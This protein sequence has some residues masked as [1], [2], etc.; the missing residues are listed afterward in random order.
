MLLIPT[1]YVN[2]LCILTGE[3]DCAL[4]GGA[5]AR[6]K[7]EDSRKSMVESQWWWKVNDVV[8]GRRFSIIASYPAS[9]SLSRFYEKQTA[10]ELNYSKRTRQAASNLSLQL[11]SKLTTS[12][13]K[14]NLIS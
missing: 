3:K 1:R 9:L 10:S 7:V 12:P 5:F 6:S 4:E 11:L 13:H 8:I 14:S 2:G